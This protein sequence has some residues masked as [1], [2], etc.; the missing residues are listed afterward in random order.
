MM[1]TSRDGP[2]TLIF[3]LVVSGPFSAGKTTLI[4]T[5]AAQSLVTT[6]TAVSRHEDAGDKTATTVGMDF[7]VFV[8]PDDEGDI[9]L[10]LHGT[11]G[12]ERFRFMWEILAEGAD[13]MVIVVDGRDPASWNEAL[14][15]ITVLQAAADAPGVVAVNW[16]HD[17]ATLQAARARFQH[18]GLEV[19]PCDA[20]DPAS[21]MNTLVIVLA[22]ALERLEQEDASMAGAGEWL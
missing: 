6:E 5:V 9:E 11:P 22:G 4:S 19:V 15:H 16:R 17:E 3:K 8:V 10:R 21:V 2:G 14:G 12:Q 1:E 13:G 20:I 7:G 18:T